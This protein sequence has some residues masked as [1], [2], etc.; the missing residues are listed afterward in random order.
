MSRDS[1]RYSV[2]VQP[3]RYVPVLIYQ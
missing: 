2:P 3:D 1:A